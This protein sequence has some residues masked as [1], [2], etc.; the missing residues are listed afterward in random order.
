M[1]YVE[2]TVI[3]GRVR[4]TKKMYTSRYHRE[5]EKRQK[6]E[7]PTPDKQKK[8]NERKAEEQL[9]WKLNAN[10]GAKDYHVVLHYYDHMK[11]VDPERGEEDKKKFLRLL[12]KEYRKAE[13][14]W[15]YIA[16]TEHKYSTN[17]HHHIIT[18]RS[19]IELIQEVWWKVVGEDNG[20]ISVKPLDK[21]GNHAKLAAYLI[22]ESRSMM[23]YWKKRGKRYKRFSCSKG[24]DCPEPEYRV[25][26]ANSW[27]NE[28]KA[29]KGWIILKDDNGNLAQTGFCEMTGYA[30]QE[31]FELWA[32]ESTPPQPGR[33]RGRKIKAFRE[34][35]S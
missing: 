15:K 25:V 9:R 1:P 26:D 19:S 4:E 27:A 17:L 20:N 3:A 14:E 33:K 11:P 16:C 5:G 7:N 2:R 13:L 18:K 31:Y 28:P 35:A 12:C 10:F 8:V 6:K 34:E 30:W 32:D 29:K 21:R 24:L 23:E 22:K